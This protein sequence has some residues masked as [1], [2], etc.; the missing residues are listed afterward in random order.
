MLAIASA[1]VR[2]PAMPEAPAAMPAPSLG[3]AIR[4]GF[5]IGIVATVAQILI[6]LALL[7]ACGIIAL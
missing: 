7:Y 3:A 4:H 1:Q 5:A 2:S 6:A